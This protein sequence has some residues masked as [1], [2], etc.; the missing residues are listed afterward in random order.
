MNISHEATHVIESYLYKRLRDVKVHPWSDLWVNY[1]EPEFPGQAAGGAVWL[2]GA[3]GGVLQ[4]L[5]YQINHRHFS[6]FQFRFVIFKC[7]HF[8]IVV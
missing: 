6:A 7:S 3:A 5:G 8:L 2:G 1:S 4:V